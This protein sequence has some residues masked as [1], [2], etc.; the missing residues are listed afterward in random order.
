MFRN[1]IG[2]DRS[3]SLIHLL[4]T[5][6][7]MTVRLK[8]MQYYTCILLILTHVSDIVLES[9]SVMGEEAVIPLICSFL[10]KSN[11]LKSQYVCQ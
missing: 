6:Q 2:G 3:L 11:H 10:L 9:I 5:L 1:L 8:G 7:K 4:S